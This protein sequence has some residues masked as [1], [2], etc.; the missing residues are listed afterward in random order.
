ML[1]G[2]CLLEYVA[3]CVRVI[4]SNCTLQ[5]VPRDDRLEGGTYSIDAE[6]LSAGIDCS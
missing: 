2:H 6:N 4:P 5:L 1:L 3:D